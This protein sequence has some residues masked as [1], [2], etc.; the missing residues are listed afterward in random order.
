MSNIPFRF[1][2]RRTSTSGRTP[3]VESLLNGELYVQLADETIYFK[4]DKCQLVSVVTSS[5]LNKFGTGSFITTGMT[6]NFGGSA[7]TGSLTGIFA[8]IGNYVTV[9]QTG[10]FITT[11]M[12]GAFGGAS[13]VDLTSYVTTGSTGNFITTLQTGDLSSVFA[14]TGDYVTATQTGDLSSVFAPTGD[15]VTA[16]QTGGLTSVFAPTGDYVTATQTGGLTSVFAPTGDYVVIVDGHVPSQYLPSYVDDIEEFDTTGHLYE[17]SGERGHIYL[18]SGC[19]SFWRWGGHQYVEIFGSPGSSD[20][21]AEGL[22]N[23]YF[24]AARS[25]G[26]VTT[27]STGSFVTT[28]QTGVFALS[29]N[30]GSFVTTSQTGIFVSTGAGYFDIKSI[31]ESITVCN[32]GST[33]LIH[34]D[35]LSGSSI[36]N[37][38]NSTAKSYLN[39][40]GNASCS[41]NSLIPVNRTLAISFLNTNGATA[42]ELT[43]IS[44]DGTGQTIRWMNGTGG[45]PSGNASAIDMYSIITVKTGNGLYNVFGSTSFLK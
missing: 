29:A 23:L 42:Y 44:I 24:T 26:Y 5:S 33:G 39:L 2:Q 9:N 21:L 35:I 31:T 19:N 10:N 32:T 43:G 34:F 6:G 18:V 3:D 22:N 15:Y 38:C 12:T 28:S 11:S 20:G 36:Y 41:L 25:A 45:A 7:N 37:I 8:P 1:L 27:G 40:R 16:T 13:G 17:H 4:N 14:P 30:T